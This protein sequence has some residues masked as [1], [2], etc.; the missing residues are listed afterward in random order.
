MGEQCQK[1]GE[2]GCSWLCLDSPG[3][4]KLKS[5]KINTLQELGLLSTTKQ[6]LE[7][8]LRKEQKGELQI[9]KLCTPE[10]TREG[11]ESSSKSGSKM[12]SRARRPGAIDWKVMLSCW[13]KAFRNKKATNPPHAGGFPNI[14]KMIYANGLANQSEVWG[15]RELLAESRY[16]P[17]LRS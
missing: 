17:C 13:Q 6:S 2:R 7:Y 12:A 5:P 1:K 10:T 4:S 8:I 15:Y 9:S 14:Y 16:L 11:E 3:G